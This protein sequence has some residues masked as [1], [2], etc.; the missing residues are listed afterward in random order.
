MVAVLIKL[1]RVCAKF[2][3][4]RFWPSFDFCEGNI[5]LWGE[6]LATFRDQSAMLGE[7]LSQKLMRDHA[8][9]PKIWPK[10]W[11]G[12]PK[13]GPIFFWPFLSKGLMKLL[14]P[15]ILRCHW[16]P[17]TSTWLRSAYIWLDFQKLFRKW[18]VNWDKLVQP[19]I[20]MVHEL[21][22]VGKE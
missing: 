10:T 18:I 17:N 22:S 9:N 4:H 8:W 3:Y 14:Q 16:E 5:F 11:P 20:Q 19:L 21:L 12:W 7:H 15:F 2:A 13:N 1:A 6:T